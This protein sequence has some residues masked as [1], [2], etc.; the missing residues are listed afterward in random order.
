MSTFLARLAIAIVSLL[1][2][3]VAF[4]AAVSYLFYAAFLYFATL[5]S[6]ALASAAT[7]GVLV[8]FAV[9]ILLLAR[10]VSALMRRRPRTAAG[11]RAAEQLEALL[12]V[13][14]ATYAAR[15]PFIATGIAFAVGI[16]MGISPKLRR[17]AADILRR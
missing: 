12:G 11:R 2:A 4:I 15:N 14:L 7:A 8:G 9:F 1:A 13:E 5:M 3:G 10:V 16:A 17:A 6:P